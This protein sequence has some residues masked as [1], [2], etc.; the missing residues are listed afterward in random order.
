MP[1]SGCDQDLGFGQAE[2]DPA[3]Q[4]FVPISLLKLSSSRFP[5]GCQA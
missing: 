1:P 5:K 2:E 3:I 4:Q